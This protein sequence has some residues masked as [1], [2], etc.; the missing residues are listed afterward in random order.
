[1]SRATGV[2]LG[3][4]E[5]E[6][7]GERVI[8][9]ACSDG[10]QFRRL[11]MAWSSAARFL[12]DTPSVLPL[13]S[14]NGN[15]QNQSIYIR[16]RKMSGVS[17]QTLLQRHQSANLP[18]SEEVLRSYALQLLTGISA[19]ERLNFCPT[20]S[21]DTILVS[22]SFSTDPCNASMDDALD[23]AGLLIHGECFLTCYDPIISTGKSTRDYDLHPPPLV[24]F[25]RVFDELCK[26]QK[27]D[28]CAGSVPY[29]VSSKPGSGYSRELRVLMRACSQEHSA[30]RPSAYHAL[31]WFKRIH[32]GVDLSCVNGIPTV[33]SITP[34]VSRSPSPVRSPS[35]SRLVSHPDYP[36]LLGSQRCLRAYLDSEPDRSLVEDLLET[37]VARRS[38][39]GITTISDHSRRKQVFATIKPRVGVA[40]MRETALMAATRANNSEAVQ[41]I[42]KTSPEL[43]CSIHCGDTSLRIASRRGLFSIVRLLLSE[44]GIRSPAGWTALMSAARH[45][46]DD[47]VRLLLPE[48]GAQ[49]QDGTSALMLACRYGH[50]NCIR[51]LR[52]VEKNLTTTNGSSAVD[53]IAE[54]FHNGTLSNATRQKCLDALAG[55]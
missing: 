25:S 36:A 15:P 51:E 31:Q 54:S 13:E 2:L 52:A 20:V 55:E 17:M 28:T 24:S 22:S 29:R 8:S 40:V 11:S 53:F 5:A 49:L 1:M 7:N 42:L 23:Y 43:L 30:L 16:F 37:A 32:A 27:Q 48:A 9:A 34:R 3:P 45:G 26:L 35:P 39:M 4:H 33:F 47:I 41:H 21:L 18:F 19:L 10:A 46:Y 44:L 50:A 6:I 38:V 12:S 14:I